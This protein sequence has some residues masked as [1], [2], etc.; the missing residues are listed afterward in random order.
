MIEPFKNPGLDRPTPLRIDGDTV[1]GHACD[2]NRL[3]TGV[4]GVRASDVRGDGEYRY[5]HLGGY[6]W[7]GKD[8]DVGA[9]TLHT[10]HADIR[11]PGDDARAHYEN[12]GAVAAYVRAGNDEHGLWFCGKLAKGLCEADVEALRGSKISGD[13]RGYQGKRELIGLL[14]VNVPGFPVERE[15]VLVAGASLALVASGIVPRD[16]RSSR[17]RLSAALMRRKLRELAAK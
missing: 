4:P 16:A 13:W 12:T 17:A 14:A 1:Y 3:H 7:Q 11:L 15:R 6:Q 10:V 8:I 2:W 9:I 5:F